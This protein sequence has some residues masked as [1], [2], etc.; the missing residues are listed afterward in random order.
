MSHTRVDNQHGNGQVILAMPDP[1]MIVKAQRRRFTAESKR[2][3][4][5]KR[6]PDP[7]RRSGRAAAPGRA[8]PSHLTT[9]R[10]QRQRGELQG[11]TPAKRGR[12]ANCRPPK[13]PGWCADERLQAQLARAE[14]IIEVQKF[15]RNCSACPNPNRRAQMIATTEQL[16]STLGLTTVSLAAGRA[17]ASIVCGGRNPHQRPRPS[18]SGS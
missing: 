14:L 12:K 2:R 15:L 10:H 4:F 1:E 7:A 17:A 5:Q 11:L 3:I 8:I 13:M 16:A 18:R 6:L 9:W